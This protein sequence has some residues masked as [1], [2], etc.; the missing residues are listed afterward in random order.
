MAGKRTKAPEF[1]GFDGPRPDFKK[2]PVNEVVLSLQF[3]PLDEFN[4][5]H[6]GV[7]W[8][9][10]RLRYP[11]TTTKGAI[12]PVIERFG[13]LRPQTFSFSV[14]EAP[15][16]PRCWFENKAGTE[17][18][19]VQRDRFLFNWKQTAARE[20]YVRYER[21]RAKFLRHLKTFERFLQENNLGKIKPNQC[22]ITYVNELHIGD[23]WLRYG[24]LAKVFAIWSGRHSDN[25]LKEPEDAVFRARYSMLSKQ[26]MPLGRLHVSCD[27]R[28][29]TSDGKQ[30]LRLEITARGAPLKKTRKAAFEFFDFAREYVVRGFA[31]ITSKR[32]HEI[33]ERTDA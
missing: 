21:V 19:Q 28:I 10:F 23:G 11:K 2:P 15:E 16:V 13:E 18:I 17:L 7:L 30:I 12:P 20:K 29:R 31:S 8:Q 3:E 9:K 27:P 4:A 14:V 25:F 24:Q 5:A 6:I 32:M 33:W 26:G 1:R 22:E